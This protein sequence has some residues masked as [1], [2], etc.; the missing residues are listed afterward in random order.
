LSKIELQ[1]EVL[2]RRHELSAKISAQ[3]GGDLNTMIPVPAG[4]RR[5]LD[6]SL[7]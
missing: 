3:L 5:E 6:G 4:V 2:A 7:K 1:P